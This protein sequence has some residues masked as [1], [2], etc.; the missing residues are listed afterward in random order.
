MAQCFE[1]SLLPGVNASD[2]EKV[3]STQVFPNFQVLRRNVR[4]TVHRLLKIDG[5]PAE[6]RYIW[7]VFVDLVGDTPETAGE[8]PEVLGAGFNWLG[9]ASQRLAKFATVSRSF[10]EVTT[11]AK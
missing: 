4:G 5:S 10:S 1:L 11:P 7:L 6:L 8:G 9:E 3:M 2:F